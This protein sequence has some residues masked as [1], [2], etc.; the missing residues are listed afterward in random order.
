MKQMNKLQK[1][2]ATLQEDLGTREIS[3]ASGGGAVH[4]VISLQQDLKSI[5]IDPEFL[6]EEATLVEETI[7]EAVREAYTKSSSISE[8]EMKTLTDEMQMAGLPGM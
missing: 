7:L 1:K 2:M 6:K 4:V 5:K 3:V 8:A